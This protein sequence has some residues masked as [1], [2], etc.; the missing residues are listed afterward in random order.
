LD[1]LA[2]EGIVA[3][4]WA[5]RLPGTDSRAIVVRIEDAGD[6]ERRVRVERPLHS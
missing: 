5:D 1:A 2:N 3:I 6:D 4:E